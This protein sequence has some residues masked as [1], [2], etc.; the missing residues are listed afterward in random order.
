M[1]ETIQETTEQNRP[2]YRH[3]CP[4]CIFLGNKRL[5]VDE[6][7]DLYFCSPNYQMT[8]VARYGNGSEDFH[9]G[10]WLAQEAVKKYQ[11]EKNVS[12][13]KALDDLIALHSNNVSF[14]LMLIATRKAYAAELLT[15]DFSTTIGKERVVINVKDEPFYSFS[16]SDFKTNFEAHIM[17]TDS[18]TGILVYQYFKG[19]CID[20]CFIDWSGIVYRINTATNKDITD[21]S[22]E[23]VNDVINEA[24]QKEEALNVLRIAVLKSFGFAVSEGLYKL[25]NLD[26]KEAS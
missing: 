10:L 20:F 14:C 6:V 9:S 7:F 16:D 15:E 2:Q 11:A 19:D 3:N 21:M 25:G 12:F 18:H 22:V 24:V 1:S 5:G 4:H 8:M 17:N 23:S 26:T 13:V